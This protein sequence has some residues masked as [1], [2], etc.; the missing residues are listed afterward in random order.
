MR[1]N[2]GIIKVP[3]NLTREIYEFVVSVIATDIVASLQ[4][5]KESDEGVDKWLRKAIEVSQTFL[6]SLDTK[7]TR[8]LYNEYEPLERL[9]TQVAPI[10]LPQAK[11]SLFSG[12]ANPARRAEIKAQFVPL[13][14]RV[15]K[16]CTE[17]LVGVED[18][19]TARFKTLI[20]QKVSLRGGSSSGVVAS[21]TF[22]FKDEDWYPDLI[23]RVP[24]GVPPYTFDVNV[25]KTEGESGGSWG[26]YR[27]VL[28]VIYR[29]YMSPQ[30]LER[31]VW[32]ILVHEMGHVAQSMITRSRM[33]ITEEDVSDRDL[34]SRKI[35][36]P[37]Y[38]QRGEDN[39]DYFLDDREFHTLLRD[40]IAYLVGEFDRRGIT[41]D[42]RNLIFKQFVG[43]PISK[44]DMREVSS[45][46]RRI[47]SDYLYRFFQSLKEN[48]PDKW[49][50]AVAEAYKIIFN[51]T[52]RL[53]SA[54]QALRSLEMRISRLESSR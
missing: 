6:K 29:N 20:T 39:D 43:L 53:A 17:E 8:E 11:Q 2:A 42:K 10:T 46:I 31:E 47:N 21:K 49:K 26:G 33:M 4:K 23:G 22:E 48:A 3:P 40:A 54:S 28:T 24:S 18:P 38:S 44:E 7:G 50:K 15:I 5:P 9:L 35:R 51:S 25:E 12:V 34:L 19:K 13:F 1:R 45:E 16:F 52:P 27:R 14:E 37:Q 30:D 36:T 41:A 32:K